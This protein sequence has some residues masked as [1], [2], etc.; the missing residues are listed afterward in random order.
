MLTASQFSKWFQVLCEQYNRNFTTTAN[1]RIYYEY[2]S[3]KFTEEEFEQV[4]A[5]WIGQQTKF[6]T[7]KELVDF[8]YDVQP[9]KVF[10]IGQ[11]KGNLYGEMTEE[12]RRLSDEARGR[13]W[14]V[15]E[16]NRSRYI[17]G[18]AGFASVGDIAP[19]MGG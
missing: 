4:V 15:L 3:A 11:P 17:R 14:A 13:I 8:W 7:P 6:P 9:P 2:L 1:A 5:W 16:T 12:E 18:C 10:S 19:A